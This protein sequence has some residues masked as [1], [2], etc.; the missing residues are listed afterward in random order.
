MYGGETETVKLLC[1]NSVINSV[2][3]K[4]GENVTII[5]SDE[6]NFTASITVKVSPTFFAWIFTFSG[7]MKI[8]G[9]SKVI[10]DFNKMLD[11]FR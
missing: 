11:A 10:E 4:F 1:H 9:P 7:K 5:K 3:D 2:I 8:L 6:E